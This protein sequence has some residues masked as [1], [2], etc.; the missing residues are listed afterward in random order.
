MKISLIYSISF[1]LFFISTVNG[2]ATLFVRGTGN[3]DNS[4]IREVKLDDQVLVNNTVT[5]ATVSSRGLSLTILDATTQQHISS[6]NYDTY[7]KPAES[8][9]LATALNNLA[10]GQIG[11]L[12][13]RDAWET[14]I[15][16]NLRVA[17]RRLGLYKLANS[18][19]GGRKPYAAL[20]YG[21]N[22]GQTN[23]TVIETMQKAQSGSNFAIISTFL[24]E[25]G[26]IATSASNV[27]LK[28]NG[29]Y[30]QPGL[31]VDDSGK[32]GVGTI[33]PDELVTV[34]GKIH[35]EEV[36][37]DLSV[38]APDYVFKDSYQLLSLE[39]L[40][41]YIRDNKHLPEV[42][43]AVQFENEGISVGT[44]NMLLLKKVEELTLYIIK[45]E[46]E[47]ERQENLIEQQQQHLQSINAELAQFK[48][49]IEKFGEN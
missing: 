37:V 14:N 3:N 15:T 6:Y 5:G 23:N 2:Q 46:H 41:K 34:K 29:N 4:K 31:I 38:P 49:L 48:K 17:A 43:S 47:S 22:I 10:R 24:I 21:A 44:M 13:S 28:A 9:A 30:D 40:E 42:P 20:F 27:L 36:R 32:V 11:I 12:C 19:G 25:D 33:N 7:G 16:D 8:E 18:R 45:Q 35:A 26:F 39:E 1:F